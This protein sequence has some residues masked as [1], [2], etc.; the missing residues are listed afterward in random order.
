MKNVFDHV[1]VYVE[2]LDRSIKFYEE[3]FGFPVHSRLNDRGLVIVFL[4]MGKALLQLKKGGS[5]IAGSGKYNHF[6]V[7]TSDY[8]GFIAKLNV[9]G[10]GYW[11][12]S[13]GPGQ[14]LVNFSDPDGHDIEVCESAF[15]S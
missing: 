12:M 4:D 5:G 11:E 14:R 3:L 7:H 15:M 6:A 9:M 13:L 8:D 1:G 10:A 2:D